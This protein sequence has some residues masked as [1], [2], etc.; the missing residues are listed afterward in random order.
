MLSLL[1]SCY[2][3]GYYNSRFDQHALKSETGKFI[4][5]NID[6]DRRRIIFLRFFSLYYYHTHKN[7]KLSVHERVKVQSEGV[8]DQ[9]SSSSSI[10]YTWESCPGAWLEDELRWWSRDVAFSRRVQSIPRAVGCPHLTAAAFGIDDDWLL[11][12]AFLLD[13]LLWPP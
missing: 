2:R 3:A 10:R 8:D 7:G 11:L 9:R 5:C 6:S 1:S 13:A 12:S 4:V